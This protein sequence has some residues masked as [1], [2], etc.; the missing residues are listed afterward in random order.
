MTRDEK[1]GEVKEIIRKIRLGNLDVYSPKRH[2]DWRLSV[3]ME[4]RG[5]LF[6]FTYPIKGRSTKFHSN[7]ATPC[8]HPKPHA[9]K[10]SNVL[11]S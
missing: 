4:V 2:V 6:S 5:A 10:G 7:S 9:T 3:N 1:S 11:L 8:G